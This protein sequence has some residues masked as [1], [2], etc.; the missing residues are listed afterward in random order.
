MKLCANWQQSSEIPP[1][2][3]DK[4]GMGGFLENFLKYG[5]SPVV[6]ATSGFVKRK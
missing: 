5:K 6:L 1:P 3:F 4:G 2:P